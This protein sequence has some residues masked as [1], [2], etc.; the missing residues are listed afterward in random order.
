MSIVDGE[1]I[2]NNFICINWILMRQNMGINIY[3]LKQEEI[4]WFREFL[5]SFPLKIISNGLENHQGENPTHDNGEYVFWP[6]LFFFLL[7]SR[8]NLII[9]LKLAFLCG[10]IGRFWFYFINFLFD[11]RKLEFY[12]YLFHGWGFL[13]VNFWV[14]CLIRNSGRI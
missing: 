2:H 9:C 12:F 8:F 13:W 11:G 10:S 14:Y 7:A 5:L 1:R 3:F 6:K 4:F